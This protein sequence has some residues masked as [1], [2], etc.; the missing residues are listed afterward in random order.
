MFFAFSWCVFFLRLAFVTKPWLHPFF[1]VSPTELSRWLYYS[2]LVPSLAVFLCCEPNTPPPPITEFTIPVFSYIFFLSAKL[3]LFFFPPSSFV[4]V[5][6][7]VFRQYFFLP[8]FGNL[9]VSLWVKG[10]PHAT[11]PMIP[12][13]PPNPTQPPL[14]L[15]K[16]TPYA[17][18]VVGLP[19]PDPSTPFTLAFVDC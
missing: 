2:F 10:T 7:T 5:R 9:S 6:S 13:L 4:F 12:P 11:L 1:F 16:T 14:T 19:P 3:A 15:F 8:F 18:P 17:E